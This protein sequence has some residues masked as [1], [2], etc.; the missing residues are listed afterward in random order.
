MNPR[1][2]SSALATLGALQPG[3]LRF[4]KSLCPLVSV[5]NLY[6]CSSIAYEFCLKAVRRREISRK[7]A[8]YVSIMGKTTK[9]NREN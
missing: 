5:S 4:I 1:A 7:D 8:L 6:L 9:H 3:A 2:P